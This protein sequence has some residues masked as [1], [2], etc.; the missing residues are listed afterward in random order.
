V[1]LRSAQPYSATVLWHSKFF[2]RTRADIVHFMRHGVGRGRSLKLAASVVSLCLCAGTSFS[3]DLD[4]LIRHGSVIDGSGSPAVPADIGVSG[5]RII[6]IGNGQGKHARRE[7]DATG[8]IVAP[9]FIDPHT[10]TFE[11][12]SSPKRK[13]NAAYLTQGVTTVLTGN[14]G[15]GPVDVGA[16]LARWPQHGIGTN[17]GLF[18]GQGAVRREVMGMSNKP[19][20]AQQMQRMEDLI[21]RAM[22]LGAIGMSTGLYYAP[23]SFSSTEE[24]IALAKRA[25][26]RGGVYDTHMRDESSYNIGL[27]GAVEETIRIG[28][29]SGI[30]VHI[31]HIKALGKD[32]WGQ[33]RQVID[34][35][36]KARADGVQITASQ[37]PYTA[38][39]TSVS[40]SL[41]PRWAEAGGR[42]ELLKRISD[43]SVKPRLQAE[44]EGNLDRRGGPESLLI[45]PPADTRIMGKTLEQ[46][47]RERQETPV[48][49][50]LDIIKAGDAGV[51]SFN[52]REDDIKNFMRQDWVM[53]CSD[54]SPGHPRKYGTFPRKLRKYV[55]DEHVITLPFA[56]RSSTSLTAQTFGLKERGLLKTGYFADIVVFDPKTIRDEA[57][58]E[59]PEVFSTGVEYVLVNGQVAV[60]RGKLTGALAGHVLIHK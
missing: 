14:D 43:P 46:I 59:H 34:V 54:G 10:H 15:E 23:G 42:A 29:E 9:G 21:D 44:M 57:T 32:V 49:A 50:A 27:M 60:D 45:T 19:P 22:Q 51:A 26:A 47:A 31:S 33:S 4:L 39:G 48:D 24:V 53:T 37:Y 58:F 35:I 11:D 2:M 52:M 41:L 16:A 1:K 7:I 17:A 36:G 3:Q 25:A 12:L 56:I 13:Q 8:L 6:F 38:S 40:A 18:I 20:S 5:N 28:K 30:P 55:L